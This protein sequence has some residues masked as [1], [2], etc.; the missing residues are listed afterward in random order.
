MYHTNRWVPVPGEEG[1]ACGGGA[2][3][4]AAAWAWGQAL[5][6]AD[7]W[8]QELGEWREEGGDRSNA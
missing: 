5:N 4:G 3:L 7:A 2:G 6:T 1:C 8:Q